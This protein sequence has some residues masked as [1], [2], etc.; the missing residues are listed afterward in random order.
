MT[1]LSMACLT[2]VARG[3]W[4]VARGAWRVARGAWRC[5]RCASRRARAAHPS[6][7]RRARGACMRR[8]RGACAACALRARCVCGACALRARAMHTHLLVIEAAE[9]DDRHSQDVVRWYPSRVGGVRLEDKLVGAHLS[10]DSGAGGGWRGGRSPQ[11]RAERGVSRAR[12]SA[13][14][15]CLQ[16]AVSAGCWWLQGAV[17]VG[18]SLSGR[19]SQGGVKSRVA[20]RGRG[21]RL[22]G[23]YVNRVEQLVV[24]VRLGRAHVP[25][26]G[27]GRVRAGSGQVRAGSGQGYFRVR[28]WRRVT[29][30]LGSPT[31]WLVTC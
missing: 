12:S 31:V 11:A 26:Q 16:G 2:C 20:S 13:G 1:S 10:Q 15:W 3:A 28:V 8:A 27:Q 29:A 9:Q 30:G 22:H 24:V 17:S 5:T 19:E 18:G 6:C 23:S 21:A 4:R 7:T 14:C 25:E